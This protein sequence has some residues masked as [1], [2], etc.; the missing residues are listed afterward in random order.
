[1]NLFY[2]KNSYYCLGYFNNLKNA[3]VLRPIKIIFGKTILEICKLLE[4]GKIDEE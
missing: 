3:I 2:W 4:N 1:M